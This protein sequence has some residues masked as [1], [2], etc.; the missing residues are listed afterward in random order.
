MRKLRKKEGPQ[1]IP[2]KKKLDRREATRERKAEAAARLNKAVEKELIHRLKSRAYGD[3]PLNVNEDVWRS[4]LEGDEVAVEDDITSES[5]VEDLV[6]NE[7][8][9]VSDV[10]DDES[11]D[12]IEDMLN[13]MSEDE[14]DDDDDIMTECV[15]LEYE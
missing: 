12:D 9:F 10:S 11:V 3:A 14:V 8:E 5:E 13:K 1:L 15:E 7:R 4:V 6:E 2:I